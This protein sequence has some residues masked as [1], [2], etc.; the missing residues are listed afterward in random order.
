[1]GTMI[2]TNGQATFNSDNEY[3]PLIDGIRSIMPKVQEVYRTEI[4]AGF[5]RFKRKDAVEYFNSLPNS[6]RSVELSK[7][8]GDSI[9]NLF[10][11]LLI[12]SG[13]T[14]LVDQGD[15]YDWIYKNTR[16]TRIE[17]KNAMSQD[18]SNRAWVG[19]SNSGRK[20]SMHLL[21]RFE[22]DENYEIV[23]AHISLVNLDDTHQYW[24][25]QGG[26]R[27]TL[28]FT[29]ADIDGIITIYGEW[30]SKTKNIFP[31]WEKI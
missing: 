5:K 10:E 1:M 19:N 31:R 27:S 21:K 8:M 16:E 11:E 7:Q 14:L 6:Q 2:L 20:V 15:G 23:G 24:V 26:A 28:S 4:L 3:T 17:D 18:P 30:E 29:N 25:D 22:L 13:I 9:N 12:E